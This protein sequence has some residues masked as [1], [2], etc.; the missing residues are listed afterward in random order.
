MMCQ[1]ISG[2]ERQLWLVV[3]LLRRTFS[4][5][6]QQERSFFEYVSLDLE[7]GYGLKKCELDAVNFI[8]FVPCM[9]KISK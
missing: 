3:F 1:G 4:K 2:Q 7:D 5:R 9:F 8:Y 6:V